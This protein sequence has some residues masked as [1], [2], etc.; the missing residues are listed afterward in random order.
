MADE[1]FQSAD[2][3]HPSSNPSNPVEPVEPVEPPSNMYANVSALERCGRA[4]R[5]D[6]RLSGHWV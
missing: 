5:S 2:V 3:G 4:G 6:V 1:Q